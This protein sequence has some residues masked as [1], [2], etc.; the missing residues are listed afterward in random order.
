MSDRQPPKRQRWTEGEDKQ[1]LNLFLDIEQG[2]MG[3]A[4]ARDRT[5]SESDDMHPRKRQPWTEEEDQQ[6]LKL[7]E[8]YRH[9]NRRTNWMRIAEQIPGRSNK[10]CRDRWAN[11]LDPDGSRSTSCWTSKEDQRLRALTEQ[12]FYV[13]WSVV[14]AQMP[15]RNATQCRKRWE[16]H[17]DPSSKCDERWSE[18]EDHVLYRLAREAKLSWGQIAQHLPG[19][20]PTRCHARWANVLDPNIKKGPWT[21]EE[22]EGWYF[23]GPASTFI[24]GHKLCCVRYIYY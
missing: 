10:Q 20:L 12:D 23:R 15:R 2:K 14:A 8:K 11:V 21:P 9:L 7:H 24:T 6:L 4:T 17:L 3:K 1:L 19:R 16:N 5:P 18:H 13:N 22:D